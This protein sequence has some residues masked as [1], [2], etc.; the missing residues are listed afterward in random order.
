[1]DALVVLE[2]PWIHCPAMQTIEGVCAAAN[3][4]KYKMRKRTLKNM[5]ST[6]VRNGKKVVV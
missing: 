5:M 2:T 1:M 3:A 6:K 4:H